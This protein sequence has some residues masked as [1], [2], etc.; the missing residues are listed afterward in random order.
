MTLVKGRGSHVF[1]KTR[2]FQG[3]AFPLYTLDYF[4]CDW[5]KKRYVPNA[6]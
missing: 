2:P 5:R 3:G 6:L 4:E 1:S